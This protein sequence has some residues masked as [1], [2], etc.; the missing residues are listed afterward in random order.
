MFNLF[1]SRQKAT[2]YLLGGIM[3]ILAASM[4]TYL[5]QTGLTTSADNDTVLAE[6]GP[7]PLDVEPE[8]IAIEPGHRFQVADVQGQMSQTA[9]GGPGQGMRCS[10]LGHS[11]L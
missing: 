2:R 5:T 6:V 7:L 3:L 10:H 11:K 4:L 1:R 8:E 9:V